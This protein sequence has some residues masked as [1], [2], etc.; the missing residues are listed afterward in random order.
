MQ[1]S[2]DVYQKH[3]ER[4]VDLLCIASPDGYFLRVNR[5]FTEILG[6]SESELLSRSFLEFI[7]PD[8]VASTQRQLDALSA[9]QLTI[10]YQ[11]RYRQADG[12]YLVLNWSSRVDEETRLVFAIARNTTDLELAISNS[13]QIESALKQ[14]TIYARTDV[15]G[16]IVEVN[17]MFC[18][19]SGYAPEE[20][21]GNTHRIINSGHHSNEFFRDMW[22]TISSGKV[23]S[24]EIRNRKK[25]G[26]LYYV[27]TIIT[28]S[29]DLDGTITSYIAMRFDITESIANSAELNRTLGILN[30]TSA[31]AK[32]GGWEL[33][34]AT[35]ELTWTDETF[36]ILE[37]EK[38]D[39]QKPVLPEGL[40]L[41]TDECQP[42]VED[43]VNR[44]VLHGEPYSL[45]VQARTAK[46]KVLWVYTNGSANYRNGKIVSVSGTIQD[47]NDRKIAE[48]N[49]ASERQKSIQ[50]SKLASLGELA[51]SMAH[52]INNPLMAI[53]GNVE[54][55][56]LGGQ[57]D[58]ATR[59]KLDSIAKSAERIAHI[60]KSLKKFSR[61]DETSQRE[62]R[63]LHSVTQEA[64]NLAMPRLKNQLV[65]MRY[66]KGDPVLVECNEIEIEQVLLNLINNSID[67]IESLEDRWID[68]EI[69]TEG[70]SAIVT[71]TDA[72]S[73]I[74]ED[75]QFRL[76]D[77]FFTTKKTGKGTGL[78][79][80]IVRGILEEHG[81]SIS[82]RHQ[83]L[84]TQFRL[85]FPTIQPGDEPH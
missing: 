49:Y 37:V 11:N 9:G 19:I 21:L 24:G 64:I 38:K 28:P 15:N 66:Q 3:F 18:E 79:L 84:N 44:A 8:D 80:S 16:V 69:S 22:Q 61:T 39:G 33:D 65:D 17:E 25:C 74:S 52:E 34:V 23:W 14:K 71:I 2:D 67:A 76:F 57:L 10:N 31:I 4:S 45:E 77:P 81:A 12:G 1:I 43:A 56:H 60:V 78:G 70:N 20:L 48:L 82:F 27:K 75:S 54:L 62:V 41:F 73:G 46:G 53:S 30:E 58:D 35:E 42:I 72:G 32:V 40:N 85:V 26:D 5:A 68:I 59:R 55:L 36:N 63:D 29:F 51:A 83:S 6:Y 13:R 50:S 47:I 7:H